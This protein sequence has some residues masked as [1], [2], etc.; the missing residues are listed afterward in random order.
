MELGCAL[1]HL[2]LTSPDPQKL[3]AFY[4][5]SHGMA[6]R[7]DG[8]TW[9][10][11]AE[12]R[13]LLVSPGPANQLVYAAY[14]FADAARWEAFRGRLPAG[15][16]TEVPRLPVTCEDAVAVRDPD[17]NRIVFMHAPERPALAAD[18]LPAAHLQHFALRT[19]DPAPMAA[20]YG[21]VLGFVISDRVQ[22]D[23]GVLR[24][25]FLR[26]ESLHHALALFRA[27]MAGFDH[28]SFETTSWDAMK[29][30]G[31]HMAAVR[32]TIVWGIGRHGPGDDVFFMVRDPDGNLAEISAE[33]EV[34]APDRPTGLWV[35]E[36]RT[37]NQWGKAIMRD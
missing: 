15:V 7:Q 36:E 24:A 19:L 26:T 17:G 9:I 34:C 2:H 12:G 33:I 25:C 22:D 32:E 16:A 3:A 27:P 23:E 10:C 18:A 1:H 21:E 30:W 31:D 35:H 6:P 20:F 29:H 11:E 4:E 14:A 13:L 37:L 28:Q 5:R 8:E